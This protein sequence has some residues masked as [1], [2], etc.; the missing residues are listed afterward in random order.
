MQHILFDNKT[1]C[2]IHWTH[3]K[4]SGEC[5]QIDKLKKIDSA[6]AITHYSSD[7]NKKFD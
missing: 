7:A 1:N 5:F 3:D 2:I 6:M 4:A